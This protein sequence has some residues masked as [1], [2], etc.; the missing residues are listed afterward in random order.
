MYGRSPVRAYQANARQNDSANEHFGGW[1]NQNFI[2]VLSWVG[3][4]II[5][6]TIELM[7][8]ARLVNYRQVVKYDIAAV[9]LYLIFFEAAVAVTDRIPIPN[10]L[11]TWVYDLPLLLK[12]FFFY[13][14]ADFGYYWTH[15]LMHTSYLWRVHK[16]HHS[17]TYM[18][19][20]A[21]VRATFPHLILFNLAFLFAFPILQGAPRWVM[22]FIM[23]EPLFRNDWMHMNVTWRSNWLE[24][25]FVTPRYHHIHHSDKLEHQ[26]QNLGSLFSFWDRLFGTYINPENVK[27]RISFGIGKQENPVRMVL[28]V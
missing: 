13:L 10:Y 21:G 5:I 14:I 2:L 11:P 3:L 8:P 22:L 26:T 27:E 16:W 17:P 15:R 19:W 6:T 25:V 9:G 18:Y 24:W 20:L 23:I 7:F 1:M 12:V 28:G 4:G